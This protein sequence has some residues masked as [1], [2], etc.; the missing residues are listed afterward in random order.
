M[1]IKI[2]IGYHLTPVRMATIKR[3]QITSVEE[4]MEKKEP[5]RTVGKN[6]NW[7]SH[8]KKENTS[9]EIPQKTKHRTIIQSSDY[10]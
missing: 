7:C 8:Y 5:S 1:Q 6:I 9:V 2:T 10:T 3:Q 4:D